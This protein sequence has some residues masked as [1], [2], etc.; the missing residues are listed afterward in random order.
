M[1]SSGQKKMRYFN[2]SGGSLNAYT[3]GWDRRQFRYYEGL[4]YVYDRGSS[5][6]LSWVSTVGCFTPFYSVLSHNS[7]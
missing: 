1:K 6:A 2:T 7:K 4:L 3:L 5:E